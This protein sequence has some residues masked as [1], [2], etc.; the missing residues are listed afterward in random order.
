MPLAVPRAL[1]LASGMPCSVVCS[2]QEASLKE[3]IMF[4]SIPPL[5]GWN[6]DTMA[7]VGAATLHCEVKHIEDIVARNRRRQLPAYAMKPT[8]QFWIST[9]IFFQSQEK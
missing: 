6:V 7:G 9:S 2:S 3:V 8:N 5:A 1:S 4:F